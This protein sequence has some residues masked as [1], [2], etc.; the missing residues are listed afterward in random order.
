MTRV[1]ATAALAL[2]LTG[3]GSL[4]RAQESAAEAQ[5]KQIILEFYEN[6]LNGKNPK[7]ATSYFGSHYTQH[8][9]GVADGAE[10]FLKFIEFLRQ[11]YPLAHSE[12]KHVFA[13][14]DYV[15]IHSQAI[16]EP[17]T[18]GAAIVDIFRLENQKIVE[19]WDVIQP[20]PETASNSN[21]MF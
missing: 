10:G 4:V 3:S 20:V 16:Q 2:V 17:G 9:P 12:P 11:K 8:N 19:H 21:G 5:N 1:I 14:G 7:A 13:D 15:I 18:R 6:T